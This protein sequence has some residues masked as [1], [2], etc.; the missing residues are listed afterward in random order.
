L[1]ALLTLVMIC[2]AFPAGG[3]T[4]FAAGVQNPVQ[5]LSDEMAAAASGISDSANGKVLIDGKEYSLLDNGYLCAYV[6]DE[7]GSFTVLSKTETLDTEKPGSFATF[8]IDGQN[9][10]FG[11]SYD[12]AGGFIVSTEIND[13]V[14]ATY[15]NILNYMIV[16]YIAVTKDAQNENSYAAKIAYAAEYFGDGESSVAARIML[17]T[18]DTDGVEDVI[19]P[20][21]EALFLNDETPRPYLILQEDGKTT[22]NKLIFA[23]FD[24]LCENPSQYTVIAGTALQDMAAAMYFSSVTLQAADENAETDAGAFAVFSTNF[25]FTGLT[26]DGGQI[27][28][29][30]EAD[31][32]AQLIFISGTRKIPTRGTPGI[33]PRPQ[34]FIIPRRK[35]T[36]TS[37]RLK[38]LAGRS[39]RRA[40][41]AG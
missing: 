13:G 21:P 32:T 38:R 35:C 12:D 14:I 41:A 9:F 23:N 31:E 11:H 7:D 19:S 24:S 28:T 8:Q 40:A 2:A 26:Y 39:W 34:R 20:V 29:P 22:P 37:P 3:L 1:A 36:S 5:N 25:G 17:D 30:V 15:W 27:G 18:P 10:I 4:A 33:N 6:N 16:Q